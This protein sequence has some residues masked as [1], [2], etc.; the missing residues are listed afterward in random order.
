MIS[1]ILEAEGGF[2][3]WPEDNGNWW[4]GKLVGTNRGITPADL[5]TWRG[6]SDVTEQDMRALTE[7]EA[8]A[9]FLA[10]YYMKFR[11]ERL[12]DV[13]EPAVFDFA[14]NSGANAIS[15]LQRTLAAFGYGCDVDGSIG[16]QTVRMAYACLDAV[17]ADIFLRA[18][19]QERRAFLAGIV[20]RKPNQAKFYNGWIERV[21]H[22][23]REL[24]NEL[25]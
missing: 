13:L 11:I 17:P 22:L 6:V 5:V 8:H 4:G 23:E 18:Y 15:A 1:G 24:L 25:A 9:I 19:M 21:D 2:Q 20:Q 14:V 12:P 10:L 16:P 7:A 3:K